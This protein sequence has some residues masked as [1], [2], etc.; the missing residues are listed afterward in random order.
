MSSVSISCGFQQVK[1]NIHFS[2][3]AI[4]E[5][6][7]MGGSNYVHTVFEKDSII[8]GSVWPS[9]KQSAKTPYLVELTVS[10]YSLHKNYIWLYISEKVIARL[11]ILKKLLIGF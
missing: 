11:Y 2:Q 7:E 5:G 3:L 4:K 9:R 8:K 1:H 10:F 6:T